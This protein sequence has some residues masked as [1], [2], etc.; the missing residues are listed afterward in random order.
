[1][2]GGPALAADFLGAVERRDHRELV[3]T[4]E[5]MRLVSK[6]VAVTVLLVRVGDGLA[7]MIAILSA[8]PTREHRATWN[9]WRAAEFAPSFLKLTA[10]KAMELAPA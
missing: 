4:F 10:V 9:L 8:R 7:A 1:V 2:I 6:E 3:E 5:W